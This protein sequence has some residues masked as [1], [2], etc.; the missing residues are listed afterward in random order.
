VISH[1]F[2]KTLIARFIQFE[3]LNPLASR[4]FK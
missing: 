3:T 4:L 2:R 1:R